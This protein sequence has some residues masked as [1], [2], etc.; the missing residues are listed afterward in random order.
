MHS[1]TSGDVNSNKS[2]TDTKCRTLGLKFMFRSP[3]DKPCPYAY[4]VT[5]WG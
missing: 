4:V 2:V 3:L 1:V 5:V